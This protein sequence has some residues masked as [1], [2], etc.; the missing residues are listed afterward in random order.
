MMGYVPDNY[1]LYEQ[2]ER[3]L[4]RQEQHLPVCSICGE[5]IWQ[6]M[7]VHIGDDWYCDEC[8]KEAREVTEYEEEWL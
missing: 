1:D 8:L 6:E 4:A 3:E 7:A 2:H 5:P